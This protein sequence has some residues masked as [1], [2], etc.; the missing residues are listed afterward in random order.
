MRFAA[1][2]SGP[3]LNWQAAAIRMLLERSGTVLGQRQEL[4]APVIS[5]S[6][7]ALLGYPARGT[8]LDIAPEDNIL[9]A[10]SSAG[11]L[12]VC[13]AF[14]SRAAA[15]APQSR[16]G[17]WVFDVDG[18]E[19]APGLNAF[20]ED[21]DVVTGRLLQ[22]DGV[23]AATCLRSGA[24]GVN[25]RS[26][27]QTVNGLLDELSR[28]PAVVMREI[29]AGLGQNA[30]AARPIAH[31]EP[32]AAVFAL[33]VARLL[34][35]R[36]A[37]IIEKRFFT[38]SWNIGVASGTPAQI[39]SAAG[40]P[41][42]KWCEAGRRRFF[43]DPF[44]AVIG[45]IPTAYAEEIVPSTSRGAI[46]RFEF[47]DGDL[48]PVERVLDKSFHL[49]Y[50]YI[51]EHESAWYAIPESCENGE[52][53]LYRLEDHGREW[54]PQAVL[55]SGLCAVDSTVFVHA[56]KF[57]LLCGLSDDGPNHKL[58]VYHADELTGPWRPHLRNPVKIDI[59]SAR[60]AGAPFM[61]DGVLHRP[62]QDCTRK[63]GRRIKILRVNTIDER[64]YEEEEVATIEPPPGMYRRG[65]HTMSSFGSSTLVDG[66][67]RD[68][69][70]RAAGWRTLRM[71]R[72]VLARRAKKTVS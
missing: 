37:A 52:V 7:L 66:L 34:L 16:L 2:H 9:R 13:I 28:W 63:Y 32:T 57:W 58:H 49:S 72:R 42:V 59:R 3:L 5:R 55:L 11:D 35:R 64:Q 39:A 12:D 50:P 25:S 51:F 33:A 19:S 45:G 6:A 38:Y 17:T 62:A 24:L 40:L 53:A 30:P 10:Q 70:L 23:G 68:F 4:R 61:L 56:G 47:A 69:S 65:L 43:A 44:G 8:P 67:H 15:A 26:L 29:G 71:L 20:C 18:A 60:P 1:I 48:V 41:P 22:I 21:L 54:H 27:A 31:R 46:V 36:A 14:D